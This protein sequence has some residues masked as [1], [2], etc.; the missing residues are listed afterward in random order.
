MLSPTNIMLA[1]L[2]CLVIAVL[3][4]FPHDPLELQPETALGMKEVLGRVS[5]FSALTDEELACFHDAAR[6]RLFQKGQILYIQDDPADY[7]YV[8]CRG[9]IKLFHTLPE[10]DEIIV[11][12]LTAH[13]MVGEEAIFEHGL[14][15]SSAQ[16]VEDAHLLSLPSSLLMAQ[17]RQSQTLAFSM[18]SAMSLQHRRH[19]S[20][21]AQ[22]ALQNAPQRIVCF[23]LRLCPKGVKH[24]IVF[25]LPYD[26]TL[27]AYT[28]GMKNATFSRALNVIRRKTSLRIRGVRVEIDSVDELLRFVYGPLAADYAPEG[29]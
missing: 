28:L 1:V 18:L 26:K 4:L 20:A 24:N 10:G 21:L 9:W 17:I 13:Q 6:P 16:V 25:D 7:F 22:N 14:H 11:D 2:S 27:I 19:S 3:P 15:T 5:L 8:V 23:L 29:F 12:M